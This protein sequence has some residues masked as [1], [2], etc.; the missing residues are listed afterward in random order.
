MNRAWQ[1][2]TYPSLTD[3]T[4]ARMQ[5]H[6]AIQN[7]AAVG[8]SF[9]PEDAGDQYGNLTWDAKLQRLVGHWI[10]GETIFRSSI[11]IQ[12]FTVYLVDKTFTTI[13]SISMQD[14]TQTEVMIW[15][16]KQLGQLGV[17]FSKINLALP[18]D[19]PPY[20]T[21]KGE[22]FHVDNMQA[23][24]ELSKLYHNSHLVLNNLLAGEK[25]KTTSI[26]CW[27]HHFDMAGSI[28][29][30]DTGDPQTSRQIGV[31]LSPGDDN[32]NEP[33]FYVSPWP[34]P[35]KDLPDI[36][37]TLGHWHEINWIGTVLPISK[38]SGMNLIQDQLRTIKGFFNQSISVLKELQ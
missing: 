38:L 29:L 17:E 15:L 5:C 1:K 2:L 9:L 18:Y 36:S 34:Y 8:R 12:D 27:P 31:G 4:Q 6:Q 23:C 24:H 14:T 22:V 28:I 33:Y 32:Y 30:L 7:V 11:S 26:R 20:P 25:I 19:I 37:G 13:S 10:E 3:M 21:A 35:T 16:E